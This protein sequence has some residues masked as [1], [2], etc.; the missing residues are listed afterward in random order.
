MTQMQLPAHSASPLDSVQKADKLLAVLVNEVDR[1]GLLSHYREDLTRIDRE[2]LVSMPDWPEF[3]W[4]VGETFSYLVPVGLHDRAH[5]FIQE[6]LN[7][8]KTA[9]V[10]R[11]G[12][13][14]GRLS[15]IDSDAVSGYLRTKKTWTRVD[16]TVIDAK[17]DARAWLYLGFVC[18]PG[19]GSWKCEFD[20]RPIPGT[21]VPP[22]GYIQQWVC[23]ESLRQKGPFCSVI[24][25][26]PE[27]I[28]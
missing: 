1:R 3:F 8:R 22:R 20:V 11:F 16:T 15:P 17:G 26:T 24:D 14:N 4:I 19:R 7:V 12:G 18:V 10:A 27:H 6:V 28:H 23:M 13:V 2:L 9:F 5:Q 21:P 25:G